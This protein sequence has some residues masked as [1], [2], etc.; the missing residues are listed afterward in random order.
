MRK[1]SVFNQVSLD[2]YIAD[3]EGDM[4]WAHKHDPEWD[5]W[6][7]SNASGDGEL[8]FGRV[9]YQQMASFWPT[10]TA[11]EMMP[12]VAER[13]NQARKVVFSRGLRNAEWQNTRLIQSELGP[14]VEALKHEAGP[15]MVLMGSA[16]IV[17]QLAELDLIDAYQLVIN[18]LI[19]GEGKSMFSGLK[20]RLGL[21]LVNTRG[22]Q[23]GNLAL[24]Y[25]RV[26]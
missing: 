25:E 22:F 14:A 6:V 24:T 20:Q 9:T 23:N 2:L 8:L 5:A 26:R 21:K 16:S 18:P 17:R 19:L 1:L 12:V 3:R 15:D 10:P 11:R 4:S 13:M 7:T